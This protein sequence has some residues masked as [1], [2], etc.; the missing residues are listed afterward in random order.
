MI[1][2]LIAR[3]GGLHEGKPAATGWFERFFEQY[4]QRRYTLRHSGLSRLFDMTGGNVVF[5]QVD[6]ER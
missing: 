4:P 3:A 6:L 2:S 1:A 5:A